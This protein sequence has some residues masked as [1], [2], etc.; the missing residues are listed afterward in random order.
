MAPRISI[1]LSRR[2]RGFTLIEALVSIVVLAMVASAGAVAVGLASATQQEAQLSQLAG[3]AAQQQVDFLL[4]QPYDDMT[5]F[6]GTEEVGKMAAP[7]AAGA[8]NRPAMLGG[9]WASLGRRTTL[10]S[11]PFTFTQYSGLVVEGMRIEVQVFGPDG[12]VYATIR[13]HRS[14]EAQL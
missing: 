14:K 1:Q 4:E 3:M 13:R 8:V 5:A 11:E 9:A 7:P 12:T 2:P 10:T 6:A